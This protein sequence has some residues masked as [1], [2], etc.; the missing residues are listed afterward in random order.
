MHRIKYT[1]LTK[2]QICEKLGITESGPEYTSEY[3]DVLVGKSLR[4][5][6]DNG[7]VLGYSFENRKKLTIIED[8]G[9][10]IESGYGALTLKQVVFFSHMIPGTQTGCLHG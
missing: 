8:D 6:T 1:K 3:S 10:A 9:E 4:I 7:P 5:V 2:E